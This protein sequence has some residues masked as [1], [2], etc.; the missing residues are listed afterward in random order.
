MA[1]QTASLSRNLSR[2]ELAIVIVII[3]V[4]FAMFMARMRSVEGA[5][6]RSMVLARYQDMQARLLTLKVR[7]VGGGTERT[8]LAVRDVVRHIGR[9][10]VVTLRSLDDP[11]RDGVPAG[12]WAWAE[13]ERL[14]VYRIINRDYF[15]VGGDRPEFARFKLEPRY[16]DINQNGRYD[17]P[18]DRLTG[19]TLR[20]IDASVLG[21]SGDRGG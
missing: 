2:M 1:I 5:A 20:P 17:E 18:V 11:D 4:L 8:P 9:G 6:E 14:L 16:V 15:E 12:S 19:A 21:G 13:A 10:D 3:A 7:F